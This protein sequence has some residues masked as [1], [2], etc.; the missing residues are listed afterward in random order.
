[1]F[2][3]NNKIPKTETAQAFANF[4]LSKV[5]KIVNEVTINN[6]IYNGNKKINSENHFFMSSTDLKECIKSIK[7]KNC[8]GY[9]RILQRILADGTTILETPL[10]ILFSKIYMQRSI[11]QQWLVSKIIPIHKKDLKTM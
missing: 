3:N 11:P 7:I 6:S 1:M 9:D 5:R 10:G 2:V 4:F 8:E